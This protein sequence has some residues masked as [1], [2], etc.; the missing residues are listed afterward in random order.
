MIKEIEEIPKTVQEKRISRREMI[1]QDIEEAINNSILKFELDGDYNYKYLAQYV[2]E[3]ADH[4]LDKKIRERWDMEERQPY[5]GD[6]GYRSYPKYYDR[7][8][9]NIKYIIVHNVK[10]PDRNHVYCEIIPSAL[11]E[12]MEAHKKYLMECMKKREERDARRKEKTTKE[13]F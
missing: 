12:M 6:D 2:R 11:D 9:R 5:E 4:V 1:K 10:Q 7:H 8:I 3:E 13:D